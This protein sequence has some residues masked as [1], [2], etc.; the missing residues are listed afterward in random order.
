[1]PAQPNEIINRASSSSMGVLQHNPP[2]ATKY[3]PA[4]KRRFRPGRTFASAQNRRA[5]CGGPSCTPARLLF[6]PA[7]ASDRL[8]CAWGDKNSTAGAS[9]YKDVILW[10]GVGAIVAITVRST[11]PLPSRHFRYSSAID[12]RSDFLPLQQISVRAGTYWSVHYR[13]S[14]CKVSRYDPST[15][16]SVCFG[17]SMLGALS[18]RRLAAAITI[19]WPAPTRI[20]TPRPADDGDPSACPFPIVAADPGRHGETAAASRAVRDFGWSSPSG[21]TAPGERAAGT[22][23]AHG[24]FAALSRNDALCRCETEDQGAARRKDPMRRSSAGR[25]R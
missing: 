9:S 14:L 24:P 25:N 13:L 21:M 23:P 17:V 8:I 3:S 18:N 5:A 7:R 11:K 20:T 16:T 1:M 19:W 6:R 2:K 15:M 22:A 4:A 12:D 10:P